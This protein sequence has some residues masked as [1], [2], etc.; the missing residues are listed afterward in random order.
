MIE[1]QMNDGSEIWYPE[2]DPTLTIGEL[3]KQMHRL[4]FQVIFGGY[5]MNYQYATVV[6]PMTQRVIWQCRERM[7]PWVQEKNKCLVKNQ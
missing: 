5:S 7:T 1:W 4:G 2:V 6:N 3:K